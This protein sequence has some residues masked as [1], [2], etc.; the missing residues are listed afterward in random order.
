VQCD[1]GTLMLLLPQLAGVLVESVVAQ[2]GA[3]V[4]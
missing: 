3:L 4:V 2:D 1:L